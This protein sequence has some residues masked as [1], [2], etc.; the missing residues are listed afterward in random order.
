[1]KALLAVALIAPLAACATITRGTTQAFTV[2]TDPGG[3]AVSTTNGLYCP[4]TP[5]TF[6]RVPREAEFVVTITKEG[7]ET[8]THNVTHQTAGS[9]GA[10]MAGN[11][12]VG[13]IIGAAIDG[14][15]GATQDL[16][17]N[18]LRVTL[19]PIGPAVTPVATEAAPAPEAAPAATETPAETTPTAA[20][21]N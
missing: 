16:V 6:A 1:M 13:G 10:A 20:P 7:Y 17:P 15:S 9:G 4:S 2:E 11:V 21:G 8:A 12:L 19:Q 5:C 14:N 18:P 3:A